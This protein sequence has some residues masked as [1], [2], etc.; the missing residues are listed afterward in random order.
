MKNVAEA[1]GEGKRNPRNIG[2]KYILGKSEPPTF[3]CGQVRAVGYTLEPLKCI[4][5][6]SLEV[7]FLQYVAGGSGQCGTCGEWQ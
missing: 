3:T 2:G 7:T 6:G 4:F 1:D 5:C